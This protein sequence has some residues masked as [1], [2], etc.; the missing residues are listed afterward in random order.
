VTIIRAAEIGGTSAIAAATAT[1]VVMEADIN[2]LM[3]W[4][5]PLGA[6]ALVGY[7]TARITT[8]RSIATIVF[9]IN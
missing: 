7:F 2:G 3:A 8:E 5:V 6:A 9:E 4:G 1:G